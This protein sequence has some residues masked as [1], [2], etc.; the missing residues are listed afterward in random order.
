MTPAF[1][2]PKMI[3][4]DFGNT[5]MQSVHPFD[6]VKGER[7]LFRHI[8]DTHGHTPE[9]VQAMAQQLNGDIGRLYGYGQENLTIEAHQYPFQRYLFE[10]FGLE[11]DLSPFETE[12]LFWEEADP[13]EPVPYIQELLDFLE[14]KGI[15]TG[16][17]SNISFSGTALKKRIDTVLPGHRFEFLIASSDYLF[18]KPHPRIFEIALRKAGLSPSEAWYCGD[19]VAYDV[20][21][22]SAAGM[23]PVWYT[24]VCGEGQKAPSC[25]HLKL[26]DWRELIDLLK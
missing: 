13:S 18:R 7:A 22:S 5:L 20:E 4:F 26:S 25:G 11:T 12:M 10:Y 6:G 24:G 14:E 16:V 23:F 17:V 15:R 8:K 9:E 1:P 19:N 3:L 21:G 2:T